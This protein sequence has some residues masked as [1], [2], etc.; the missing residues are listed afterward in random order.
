VSAVGC[1]EC[2]DHG[3]PFLPDAGDQGRDVLDG[4][5]RCWRQAGEFGLCRDSGALAL[6]T[7][8]EPAQ[9]ELLDKIIDGPLV[10][11]ADLTAAGVL[12]VST[13]ARRPDTTSLPTSPSQQT[14]SFFS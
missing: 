3:S 13:E 10:A 5:W 11:V 6:L 8:I 12:P 1:T 4:P 2:F 9:A 7:E 14:L